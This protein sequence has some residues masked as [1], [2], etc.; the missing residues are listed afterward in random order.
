MSK[1]P[2]IVIIETAHFACWS[3]NLGDTVLVPNFRNYS[4]RSSAIRGARRFWDRVVEA[5]HGEDWHDQLCGHNRGKDL[6]VREG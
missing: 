1:Q 4:S 2:E 6:K 5:T 3:I